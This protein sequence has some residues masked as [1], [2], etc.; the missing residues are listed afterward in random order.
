MIP[1]LATPQQVLDTWFGPDP[2]AVHDHWFQADP[3]FD[4][5]LHTRFETTVQAGLQGGLQD[6]ERTLPGRQALVLVLDQFTRNLY[7]H[8]AAAFAGDARALALCRRMLAT[9]D[10]QALPVPQRW[11][12]YMP[13]MHAEDRAAQDLSVRLFTT[14]AADDERLASALDYARRHRDVILRFGRYPHRNDAL[15]RTSSDAEQ[16]FLR[17]PGSRF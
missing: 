8:Q 16:A 7:R 3:A 9:G 14:L 13:L 4:T 5:L 2:Q 17:Q 6:W 12:V 11:F 15:G 1:A 10:D